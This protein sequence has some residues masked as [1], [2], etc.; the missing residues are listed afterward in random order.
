ME[1][2]GGIKKW[3]IPL[4]F[5]LVLKPGALALL[6]ISFLEFAPV[7]KAK[8]ITAEEFNPTQIMLF[9]TALCIL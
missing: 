8:E 7:A 3:L 5:V 2:S 4:L 9:H 1:K 6:F